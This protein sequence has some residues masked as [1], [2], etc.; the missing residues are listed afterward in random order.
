MGEVDS[1]PVNLN[2]RRLSPNLLPTGSPVLFFL[3]KTALRWWDGNGSWITIS[4]RLVSSRLTGG[5]CPGEVLQFL[6]G[7]SS[8]FYVLRL[9][10]SFVRFRSVTLNR[11]G[12]VFDGFV[13][14]MLVDW[15]LRRNV[16]A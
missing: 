9:G 14:L 15:A 13:G 16:W 2:H 7:G 12:F 1:G 5:S 4:I 11:V 6:D 8:V 10:F 3:L